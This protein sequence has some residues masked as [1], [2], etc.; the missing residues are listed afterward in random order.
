[1]VQRRGEAVL[2]QTALVPEPRWGDDENEADED[3]AAVEVDAL[4]DSGAGRP[5]K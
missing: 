1:L 3:E 4:E 2:V 5:M